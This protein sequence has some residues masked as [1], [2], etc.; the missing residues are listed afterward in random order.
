MDRYVTP[1]EFK[2]WE[3]RAEELGFAYCA[4]GPM[5]R[6]SYKAGEYFLSALVKEKNAQKM[7]VRA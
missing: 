3:Q 6:S 5:V 4:S 1:E 7:K 2:H